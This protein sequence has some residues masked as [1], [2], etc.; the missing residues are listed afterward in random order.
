MRNLAPTIDDRNIDTPELGVPLVGIGA[1]DAES[2]NV[3]RRSRASLG[4]GA[5]A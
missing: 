2:S 3:A 4:S 5:L 1:D